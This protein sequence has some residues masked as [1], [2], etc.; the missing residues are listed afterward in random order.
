MI[1]LKN[2]ITIKILQLETLIDVK[3]K[4]ARKKDIVMLDILKAMRENGQ[5]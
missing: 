3:E 2:D 5:P 1:Q 4:T